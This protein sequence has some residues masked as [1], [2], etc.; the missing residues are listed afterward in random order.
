MPEARP[1]IWIWPPDPLLV[2]VDAELRP[3]EVSMAEVDM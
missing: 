2:R 3:E 1:V